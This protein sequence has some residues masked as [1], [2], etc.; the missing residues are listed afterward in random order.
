MEDFAALGMDIRDIRIIWARAVNNNLQTNWN[1]KLTVRVVQEYF[2]YEILKIKSNFLNF[3]LNIINVTSQ[4][5][6]S[7]ANKKKS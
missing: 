4:R 1:H 7:M 2:A 5:P 3:L 6:K